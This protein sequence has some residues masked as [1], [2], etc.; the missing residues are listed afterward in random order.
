MTDNTPLYGFRWSTEW[1]GSGPP[2][3]K[4]RWVATG[5]NF[6]VSGGAATPGLGAGDPVTL[7]SGGSVDLCDGSETTQLV[8]YGIVVGVAPY[9]NATTG[10]MT[11]SDVLP[12]GVA[13]GT[14]EERRSWVYVVP[15]DAGYWEIDVD[16]AVT[17]T[18]LSAYLALVGQNCDHVLT[19]ASGA[20]RVYPKLDIQTQNTTAS[21]MWRIVDVSRSCYNRDFYGANVKLIVKANR[22]QD[23]RF[24]AAGETGI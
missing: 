17:A 8:P 20:S 6:A 12:S 5:T 18:T 14:V 22:M 11:P 21:L 10:L 15:A 1:N 19:G 4:R 24:T 9:Y 7:L 23:P 3:G 13:W 16:D 2:I